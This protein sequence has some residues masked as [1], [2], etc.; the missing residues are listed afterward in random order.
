M[1]F[2]VVRHLSTSVALPNSTGSFLPKTARTLKT[3]MWR[4]DWSWSFPH[5]CKTT[6]F[7]HPV[8]FS[9]WSRL[10]SR[11]GPQFFTGIAEHLMCN[12]SQ[13]PS[14]ICTTKTKGS[15]R[16][17]YIVGKFS[18]HQCCCSFGMWSIQIFN[19]PLLL[20]VFFY[21]KS[22]PHYTG[23]SQAWCLFPAWNGGCI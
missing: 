2:L 10:L 18:H 13:P 17:V 15:R 9:E 8:F 19:L 22:Y 6:F 5:E 20:G 4:F 21:P 23:L 12:P 3:Y 1:F 11:I 14:K 7:K 16:S